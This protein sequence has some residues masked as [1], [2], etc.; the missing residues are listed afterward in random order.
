MFGAMALD[1]EYWSK[2]IDKF[3]ALAPVLIPN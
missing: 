1:E 2:R 3:V